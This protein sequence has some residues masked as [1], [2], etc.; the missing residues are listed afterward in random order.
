MVKSNEL[1][2]HFK[3]INNKVISIVCKAIILN[4]LITYF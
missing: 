3:G 1:L 2:L 4:K